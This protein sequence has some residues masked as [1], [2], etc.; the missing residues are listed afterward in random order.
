MYRESNIRPGESEVLQSSYKT[1]VQL[2]IWIRLPIVFE[3]SM[4]R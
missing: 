4:I 3:E 2:R 1:S